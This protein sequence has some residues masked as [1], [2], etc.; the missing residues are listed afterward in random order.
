[1][2]PRENTELKHGGEARAW[3]VL[4]VPCRAQ[5][6]VLVLAAWELGEVAATRLQAL[7]RGN[8]ARK[9]VSPT[10]SPRSGT[11][12][13]AAESIADPAKDVSA[14]EAGA[15]IVIVLSVHGYRRESSPVIVVHPLV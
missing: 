3:R 8:A 7:H 6:L 4:A 1:M 2:T 14:A 11:E 15:A 10:V 13:Q 9:S 5:P 12:P